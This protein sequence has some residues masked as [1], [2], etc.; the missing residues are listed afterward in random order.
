MRVSKTRGVDRIR[1]LEAVGGGV[2]S[3]APGR[4]Y[5][6]LTTLASSISIT[7]ADLGPF[8]CERSERSLDLEVG[9]SSLSLS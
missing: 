4:P 9:L 1:W 8:S 2:K 6:S 5:R 3:A 7:A